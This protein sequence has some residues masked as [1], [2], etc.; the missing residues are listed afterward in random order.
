MCFPLLAPPHPLI[1]IPSLSLIRVPIPPRHL[2]SHRCP[3]LEWLH[4]P[5]ARPRRPRPCHTWLRRP[6]SHVF[7]RHARPRRPCLRHARPRR[8]WPRRRAGPASRTQGPRRARPDSPTPPLFIIAA[9]RPRLWP[10]SRRCT[11]WS[12]FTATPGTSTRW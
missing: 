2:A 10:L 7:L 6:R 8:L 5:R 4:R 11:T 3:H 1:S 12:P 9:S